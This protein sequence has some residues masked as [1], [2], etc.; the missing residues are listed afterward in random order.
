MEMEE[1]EEEEEAGE[2]V[3]EW[4]GIVNAAVPKRRT[5]RRRK[6]TRMQNK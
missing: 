5:T 6:R 1:E 4:D 3:D 2:A